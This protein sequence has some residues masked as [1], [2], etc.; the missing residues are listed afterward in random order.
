MKVRD[1]MTQPPETCRLYTDLAVA[2]R[3]MRETGCGTLAVLD[4]KGQLAGILTDRDLAIAVGDTRR[5]A[6]RVAV[7]KAMTHHVQTCRPDDDLHV[8]LE[9]MS[10]ARVRRLPVVAPDGEV[11]G[12][13][14]IDDIILWGLNQE[15][16]ST[17]EL[18]DALRSIVAPPSVALAAEP[19]RVEQGESLAPGSTRH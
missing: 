15:G 2:S 11:H 4:A 19:P 18:V 9:R 7:D 3:R 1:I 16:V 13:L 17:N 14:S 6:S 8:A 10:S 5:E 12:L